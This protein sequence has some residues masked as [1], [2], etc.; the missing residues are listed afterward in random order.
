M[1]DRAT[2]RIGTVDVT[3]PDTVRFDLTIVREDDATSTMQ[4]SRD[5]YPR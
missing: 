5:F 1:A 4:F 3:P 2:E